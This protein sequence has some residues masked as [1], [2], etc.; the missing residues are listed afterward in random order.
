MRIDYFQAQVLKAV[1]V[2]PTTFLLRFK[3]DDG[4]T[5]QAG[6][7]ISIVL[8]PF[9]DKMPTHGSLYS[10]ASSPIEARAFG[11]DILVKWSPGDTASNYLLQLKSG[12]TF[13]A[14]GPYGGL[15]FRSQDPNRDTVLLGVGAGIAMVKSLVGSAEFRRCP[16]KKTFCLQ[17]IPNMK[18]LI[19]PNYF[20]KR[21]VHLVACTSREVV[22]SH[23]PTFPGRITEYLRFAEVPWN[24]NNAVFYVAGREEV[25][26]DIVSV[27]RQVKR[28]P[29]ERI[30]FESVPPISQDPARDLSLTGS[31]ENLFER[32]MG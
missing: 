16:P 12:D 29:L 32:K 5:Y 28:V 22:K 15:P 21:G 25:V 6:Q 20:F 4:F 9:S 3:L 2:T 17:G 26:T 10:L 30:I 7:S 14:S 11:H 18:E 13:F 19:L 27:L 8:P 23:A 24:W 1:W 31:W